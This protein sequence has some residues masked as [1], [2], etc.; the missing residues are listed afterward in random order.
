MNGP[1]DKVA[2]NGP[3]FDK[4]T[5]DGLYGV[6]ASTE[7]LMQQ[8]TL[9]ECIGGMPVF[10]KL[11]QRLWEA[12]GKR[13]TRILTVED[14]MRCV[15]PVLKSSRSIDCYWRHGGQVGNGYREQ[16]STTL[17]FAYGNADRVVIDV[18]MC[19]ARNPHPGKVWPEL[20][21]WRGWNAMPDMAPWLESMRRIY[22]IS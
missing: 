18:G 1:F 3:K 22:E 15:L 12:N 14:V 4:T 8:M 9:I 13:R 20:K 11:R 17:A 6:L 10:K 7:V 5:A 19:D 2:M 21:P 16:A